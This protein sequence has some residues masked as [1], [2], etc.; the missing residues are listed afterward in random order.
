[1]ATEAALSP[2]NNLLLFQALRVHGTRDDAFEKVSH[3][4]TPAIS[5]DGRTDGAVNNTQFSPATLKR[6]YQALLDSQIRRKSQTNIRTEQTTTHSLSPQPASASDRYYAPDTQLITEVVDNLY[7]S[8]KNQVIHEIREDERRYDRLQEEIK[9]LSAGPPGGTSITHASL[10]TPRDLKVPQP[11]ELEHAGNTLQALPPD[12]TLASSNIDQNQ[13]ASNL[14]RLDTLVPSTLSLPQTTS[15]GPA[16]PAPDLASEK[17]IRSTVEAGPS[18]QKAQ[19]GTNAPL[20]RPS[21]SSYAAQTST[22][23][24]PPIQ[25][26][27]SIQ[28]APPKAGGVMLP[29]FQVTL[30]PTS[31]A[32]QSTSRAS[33]TPRGPR[34]SLPDSRAPSGVDRS[35]D[36]YAVNTPQE[37]NRRITL[38]HYDLLPLNNRP[39]VALSPGSMTGWRIPSSSVR[40]EDAERPRARSI[41]PISD[42][43]QS[44]E[45][46]T[47]DKTT[48][49]KKRPGRP[50]KS[51][52]KARDQ[53][54]GATP[55]PTI[56][57][58]RRGR[59]RSIASPTVE[60]ATQPRDVSVKKEASTPA[61]T[62]SADPAP[63]PA[64]SSLR[65]QLTTSKR[66]RDL[67]DH[68]DPS[69]P[70][71]DPA[72]DHPSTIVASRNFAK[73]AAPIMNQITSHKHASL[74][75]NPVKER[76][77]EGYRD[78]IR[79]PQ[80]LKS[81]RAAISIGNRAVAAAAAA[82]ASA[83][84]DVGSPG[85]AGGSTITLPASDD[86]MPPR[87]IV[88]GAQLEQEIMRMLANAVM[89]NPGEEGVVRDTR[90][91]FE[92]IEGSI[93][94]WRAAERASA[95]IKDARTPAR[96]DEEA[97]EGGDSEHGSES[98]PVKRR[99]V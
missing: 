50:P 87:A 22:Q 85:G 59:S 99:R 65:R 31:A 64:I 55:I 90:E 38:P 43:E 44:P 52:T 4:L 18:P 69:T 56:K 39:G 29:P 53:S 19:L 84:D 5:G 95:G 34:K 32:G 16:Y 88:N 68:G 51:A 54:K 40:L 3:F 36:A 89:F 93:G 82:A 30:Q 11:R 23:R 7:Q 79:R 75:A 76:D 73:M 10:S 15:L 8:Y 91:M 21:S 81:I 92:T 33:T 48:V 28:P 72:E 45:L 97:D 20:P 66:K 6:H 27:P 24:L 86:L 67:L 83:S 62:P 58:A 26:A 47:P 37:L 35:A 14:P 70:A 46:P 71:R 78:M 96:T 41:S 42:K 60:P 1:M 94:S 25:P 13:N 57:S 74:F 61:G 17:A 12:T 77:A 49:Q 98:V 9:A 2:L 80:D 63:T